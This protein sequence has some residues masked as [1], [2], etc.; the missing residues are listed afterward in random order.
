MA[1]KNIKLNYALKSEADKTQPALLYVMFTLGGKRK[2]ISLGYKVVPEYWDSENNC[3]LISSKQTQLQQREMK[4]INKFLKQFEHYVSTLIDADVLAD[5]ESKLIPSAVGTYGIVARLKEAIDKIKGKEIQEEKAHTFTPLEYFKKVVEEMPKKV[6]R[7][8]SKIIEDRTVGHHKIVLKRFERFINYKHWVASSFSIF[9]KNFESEMEQWMLGVEEYSANTVAA[10]FSVMKVWLKQAEEEGL[11]TDKSFHSW[12]SKGADVQ[13][14]YLND[15]ELEAIYNL[16]FDEILKLHPNA[17]YEETRD[18]F[19]IASHIGIR[20]G[21]LSSLNKS[22]WDI[23]NKTVE[24]HT[25]K[26]G[27]TV[28]VPLT[29]TV[30]ELYKKYNGKFPT[31]RDKSRFNEQLQ[32]IGELAGID[33]TIY[34]KKNVG[35]KVVIEEKKKYELISSH[36]ARRS[37]A[38]NLYLRC[39]NARL[40]MNFTGHTTEENFRKYICVEKSEYVEMAREFFN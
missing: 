26:T 14:I 3:V 18:I 21:D 34:I 32:K 4:R 24:I 13:H 28:L 17:K 15:A 25:H 12:K 7:R 36:T 39:R 29:S 23:E 31:P 33:Q 2:K 27:A 16:N 30:I 37:F 35:G 1:K 38:T 5:Y 22:N 8:T 9:N 20:Y 6:I 11:I 10:T 40:V 19:I